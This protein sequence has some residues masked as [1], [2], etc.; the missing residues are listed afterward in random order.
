MTAVSLAYV[1]AVA[2]LQALLGKATLEYWDPAALSVLCILSEG[3]SCASASASASASAGR[4][5]GMKRSASSTSGSKE[6]VHKV[7]IVDLTVDSASAIGSQ[8]RRRVS[9]DADVV[10]LT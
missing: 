10:D 7:E 6:R 2:V 1:C 4:L 9:N 3:S 5:H 8:L